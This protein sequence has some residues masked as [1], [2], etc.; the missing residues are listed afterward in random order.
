MVIRYFFN[1]DYVSVRDDVEKQE[2]LHMQRYNYREGPL[3]V[4]GIPFFEETKQLER[5][6]EHVRNKVPSLAELGRRTPGA[7]LC[8]RTNSPK[9]SVEIHYEKLALDIGISIYQGESAMVFIG[10][11][12]EAYYAGLVHPVSYEDIM[13]RQEFEKSE[14]LEDITI[15]LPRNP[16]IKEIFVEV[17]DGMVVLPP[18][19]YIYDKPIL[20]YGSSITEGG[21]GMISNSYNALLSR[22][23]DVDYYNLGFSGS[24][25]GELELAEYINTIEKSVFVY[26]YDHNAPDTEHLRKTHEPFFLKIREQDPELPIIM[27]SKPDFRASSSED[28][29]NREVIR[30]TYRN[31]VARGDKHV[32][33]VDGETF[34][35]TVDRQL[36]TVD[37]IHPNDLGFYRIAKTLYPLMKRILEETKENKGEKLHGTG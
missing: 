4:Y 6:P 34:F 9:F 31:A 36:C 32:Y 30:E 18:T 7:R 26:D 23:L 29:E 28:V 14:E 20:Y 13:A 12:Q 16:V 17:E 19:P 3:K 5:L 10:K 8:F 33:F 24:A 25:R 22:W 15:F 37:T 21:C 35:G 2:D 11:R 1:R 27:I